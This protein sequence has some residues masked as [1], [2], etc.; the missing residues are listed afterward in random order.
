[1]IKINYNK[2]LGSGSFGTVFLGEYNSAVVAVKRV[3]S[4]SEN[5]VQV[6]KQLNHDNI[7]KLLAVNYRGDCAYL[8]LE[9]MQ[10]GDLFALIY[11]GPK[12]LNDL[13][14]VNIANDIVSGLNYL[15]E[16]GFLHRDIKPEN[17]L[18][19]AGMRAKIAD[20]G[21]VIKENQAQTDKI[22][23][24]KSYISPDLARAYLSGLDKYQY[25]RKTDVYALGMTL[26]EMMCREHPYGKTDHALSFDDIVNGHHY[27]IPKR[28]PQVLADV[29]ASCLIK[30]AAARMDIPAILPLFTPEP[31][32]MNATWR[33]LKYSELHF[34]ARQGDAAWCWRLLHGGG[35]PSLKNRQDKMPEELWPR[36]SSHKNPFVTLREDLHRVA[37][38]DS[39]LSN[40]RRDALMTLIF[41]H[42]TTLLTWNMQSSLN[43]E[44][45]INHVIAY[46]NEEC[47]TRLMSLDEWPRLSQTRTS[48]GFTVLHI[49]AYCG[50]AR[51]YSNLGMR[52]VN[53][54]ENDAKCTPLHYAALGGY[55]EACLFLLAGGADPLLKNRHHQIAED[56]WPLHSRQ[57]NPFIA[58]REDLDRLLEQDATLSNDRYDALMTLMFTQNTRLLTCALGR[59]GELNFI[60]KVLSKQHEACFERLIS[61]DAWPELSQT[62][63]MGGYTLWHYITYHDRFYERIKHDPCLAQLDINDTCN[64]TQSSPLHFAAMR[65]DAA[66]CWRL[67]QNK[68]ALHLKNRD[69]KTAE[70]LWPSHLEHV[71][72]FNVLCRDRHLEIK[73]ERI[74]SILDA[75]LTGSCMNHLVLLM[76]QACVR[77]LYQ[78]VTDAKFE[79]EGGRSETADHLLN[80]RVD[81]WV[82][83]YPGILAR[84]QHGFFSGINRFFSAHIEEALD[85]IKKVY[86]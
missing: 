48:K 12:P 82:Q 16:H 83:R 52:D 13:A 57:T 27:K 56:L 4:C 75:K 76:H 10:S 84:N 49:A 38:Q 43:V 69:G 77:D 30:D 61:H 29:I 1:M 11:E 19:N 58:L 31:F 81:D 80:E 40:D 66:W 71:N 20:F 68:A 42:N 74:V 79:S 5:E 63:T 6:Q 22:I 34:A 65:G 23:G 37:R 17:I 15:H 62:R 14:C 54:S 18:F 51:M 60:T 70:E 36:D 53:D 50:Q 2:K 26:L 35:D 24:T 78:C 64:I 3:E 7:V 9:F 45:F 28:T 59:Y 55:A 67:F 47:M 73:K 8:A 44:N 21:F 32:N 33:A 85:D 25:N 41:T 86:S 72:P 46:T 39:T